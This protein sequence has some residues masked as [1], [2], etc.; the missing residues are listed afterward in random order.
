VFKYNNSKLPAKISSAKIPAFGQ[1]PAFGREI[2]SQ[3]VFL[4]RCWQKYNLSA[5]VFFPTKKLKGTH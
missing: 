5:L 2:I 4:K 3:V 1:S